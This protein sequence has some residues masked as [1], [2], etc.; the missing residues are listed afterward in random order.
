MSAAPGD[1]WTARFRNAEGSP[2]ELIAARLPEE[3]VVFKRMQE[4]VLVDDPDD[5]LVARHH[6]GKTRTSDPVWWWRQRVNHLGLDTGSSRA[7]SAA[8][9]RERLWLGEI[10]YRAGRSPSLRR[11]H[12]RGTTNTNAANAYVLRPGRPSRPP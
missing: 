8:Q 7:S 1:K 12:H 3:E 4:L 5:V 2:L 10:R 6:A 9:G 11:R